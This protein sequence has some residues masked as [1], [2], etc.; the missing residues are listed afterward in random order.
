M[1][2]LWSLAARDELLSKET[3]P[4]G[5]QLHWPLVLL[6]LESQGDHMTPQEALL[7]ASCG[8]DHTS[9]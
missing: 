8:R 2:P 9:V 3:W 6:C 1:E 5:T 7:I 4:A